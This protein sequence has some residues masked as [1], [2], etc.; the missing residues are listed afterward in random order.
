LCVV[1]EQEASPYFLDKCKIHFPIDDEFNKLILKK[2]GESSIL[3][4]ITREIKLSC[5]TI[6]HH[7][8]QKKTK[9]KE[10]D[11]ILTSAKLYVYAEKLQVTL[12]RKYSYET[13]IFIRKNNAKK[14]R[15]DDEI[16]PEVSKNA[17][18]KI[19]TARCENLKNIFEKYICTSKSTHSE[20]F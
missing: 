11:G 15:K 12:A 10:D 7:V 8:K 5:K 20:F 13:A 19:I 14:L 9:L 3:K 17:W 1:Q 2:S 18:K 4:K 16:S 6:A